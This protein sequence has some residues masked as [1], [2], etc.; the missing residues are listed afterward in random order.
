MTRVTAGGDESRPGT[1]AGQ[2]PVAGGLGSLKWL[3]RG[4]GVNTVMDESAWSQ[5]PW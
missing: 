1:S 3:S 5:G 4:S 2:G